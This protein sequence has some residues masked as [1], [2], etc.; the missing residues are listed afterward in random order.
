MLHPHKK[1]RGLKTSNPCVLNERNLRKVSL[2]TFIGGSY[3]RSIIDRITSF[4]Q[5]VDHHNGNRPVWFSAAAS[6][7]DFL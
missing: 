2:A 4:L 6:F 3:K 5:G 1:N 7:A